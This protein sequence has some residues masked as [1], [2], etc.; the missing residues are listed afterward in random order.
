MPDRTRTELN[1][2]IKQIVDDA[3]RPVCAQLERLNAVLLA[4]DDEL[5][6]PSVVK[7]LLTSDERLE[8]VRLAHEKRIRR[9]ERVGL[10]C[11]VVASTLVAIAVEPGMVDMIARLVRLIGL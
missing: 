2:D 9:L 8:Q 6:I 4:G 10:L 5:G 1:D 7:R 11:L 3:L